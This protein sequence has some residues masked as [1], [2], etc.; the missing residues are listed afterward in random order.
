MNNPKLWITEW[1]ELFPEDAEFNG[2]KLRSKEK[3]CI[4]KMLKFV[5]DHPIYTKDIIFAAT[6]Q[7]I[8]E[9]KIQNWE[10]TKQATYFISKVGQPSLLEIYCDKII[11]G[12]KPKETYNIEYNPIDDFI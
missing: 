10:F 7:Y 5:K 1:L 11:A 4:N 12:V 8:Q 3:D 2:Y 9:K 6:K